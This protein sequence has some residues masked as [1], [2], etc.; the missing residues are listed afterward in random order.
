VCAVVHNVL[1]VDND[2]P[3]RKVIARILAKEGY[4]VLTAGSGVEALTIAR[5]LVG[6]L[7]LVVTD[8]GMPEMNGIALA[9][10]LAHLT[11]TPQVLFMSGD[12]TAPDGEL[13]GQ[14]LCKPFTLRDFTNC[15][16]RMLDA[17]GNLPTTRPSTM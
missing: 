6:R 15:V 14:F 16:R 5:T 3:L 1:V 2:A 11:P 4:H 7:P 8:L 9:R 12:A 13:P 10:H 17:P